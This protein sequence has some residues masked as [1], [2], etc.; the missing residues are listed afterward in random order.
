MKLAISGTYSSGKTSTVM[1]LSYYTGVP[2]TVARAI[3]EIMPEA[4][5]G[6]RL[7]EVTPAEYLQLAVRRHAG[8]VAAE[9]RLGDSFV[10]D[11]TSLQEWIYAS[12]RVQFG[13]D[14]SAGGSSPIPRDD[15]DPEMLFFEKVTE[16]YGHAFRQHVAS[17]YDAMV[18]LVNERPIADDGHR[19]MN[20]AFRRYCDDMLLRSVREL[21]LPMTELHGSLEERVVQIADLHSMPSVMPVSE[22]IGM[23]QQ[24]YAAIDMRLE[25][26]RAA[27]GVA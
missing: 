11:G 24:D 3:R 9:A 15:L 18:H 2:R 6:K 5:P 14:P 17:T 26:E 7:A 10:S 23:M 1:A 13:M 19:P 21:G 25:H 16:Q 27:A 12:A 4:V 22:A 8:R 20:E